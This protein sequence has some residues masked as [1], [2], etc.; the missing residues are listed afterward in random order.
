MSRH[1]VWDWNGTLLDDFY[2]V[3]EAVNTGLASFDVG[4][5]DAERYRNHYTRPVKLF[6]DRL[7]G[8]EIAESEWYHIDSVYQSVYFQLSEQ[9]GLNSDA[10]GALE[11][12]SREA[13]GQSLLSMAL[14][15]RLGP[16]VDR[17]GLS[18][19]FV[20]VQGST[21]PPGGPKA[22]EL[23]THLEHIA[24]DPDRVVMIGDTPDDARA[25]EA[26]GAEAVLYDGGSHHRAD[27]ETVGFPW[28]TLSPRQ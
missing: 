7:I 20:R 3:V 12:A 25:A 11:M 23:E 2:I 26:V 27:L 13:S 17:L 9:A 19:H 18:S 10:A 16:W 22:P 21:G 5:V 15:D 8:R 28:L 1:I 14:H 6:Y 4:T 24:I